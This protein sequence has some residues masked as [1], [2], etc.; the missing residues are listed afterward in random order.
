MK[1]LFKYVLFS[2]LSLLVFQAQAIENPM[3]VRLEQISGQFLGRPYELYVLGEGETGRYD[4][5]PLYRFDAFDCETYVTTVLALALSAHPQDY[6]ACLRMLRYQDGD[7]S[8]LKRR[9]FT[10]VDWNLPHQKHGILKDI[11][12]T[13]VDADHRPVYQLSQTLI[14]KG[15]WYQHL[16]VERIRLKDKR[17]TQ[18]RLAE[19]KKQGAHLLQVRSVLPYLPLSALFLENGKPNQ[20]LFDQFPNGAIVEIVRPNWQLKD[21]IGTNL[22]VSHLGFVFRKNGRLWFRNASMTLHKVVDQPLID[23]LREARKSPTIKGVNVQ[24][25]VPKEPKQCSI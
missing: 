7:V 25:V 9:H 22:D 17:L 16:P 2:V 20:F 21:K 11:T 3:S 23:Y 14:D 5:S 24:V 19:L 10:S 6:Q 18:T 4:Q 15:G 8:F 1:L 13:F 12:K